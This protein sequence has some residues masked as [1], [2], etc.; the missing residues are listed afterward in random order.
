M[1]HADVVIGGVYLTRVVAYLSARDRPNA[2]ETVREPGGDHYTYEAY[3][4]CAPHGGVVVVTHYAPG[5]KPYIAACYLEPFASEARATHH[6]RLEHLVAIT[7][8]ATKAHALQR[9]ALEET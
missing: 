9:T 8:L 1:K 7:R 3:D 6:G 5:Q 4:V 2:V